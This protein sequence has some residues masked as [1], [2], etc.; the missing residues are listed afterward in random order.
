MMKQSWPDGDVLHLARRTNRCTVLGP[1]TRFVLW[2]QG[3]PFRCPSCVAPDTLPFEGGEAIAVDT[4]AEEILALPDIDGVTF[5]GGEPL[6]QAGALVRLVD[7][8]RARRDLSFMAYTG[9]TLEGLARHATAEQR[10]L[11]RRL[12]IL[13]DGP[14]VATRHTDLIWRGSDNQRV[15]LLSRRHRDLLGAGLLRRGT[16]LE[17]ETTPETLMWMGIPPKGFADAFLQALA[18]A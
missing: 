1:G 15:L 9:H 2:V 5:S 6:S 18:T 11:L 8:I 7:R 10:E 12:D 3:C 13:V 4:L 14:Y 17:F 16:W